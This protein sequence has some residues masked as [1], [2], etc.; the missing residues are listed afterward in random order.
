MAMMLIMYC[1]EIP[2]MNIISRHNYMYLPSQT[3]EFIEFS[4]CYQAFMI[5]LPLYCHI[6]N[7]E[8]HLSRYNCSPCVQSYEKFDI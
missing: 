4:F 3:A 8:K 7:K 5:G 1:L 6:S 2:V